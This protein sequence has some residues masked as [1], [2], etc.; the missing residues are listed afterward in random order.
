MLVG[1][2][3]FIVLFVIVAGLF[4]IKGGNYDP[5][6]PPAAGPVS[7]SGLTQPL[8]QWIFGF[9][10]Q[11]YGVLGIVS[12]ASV[13][14]FAYIGFDVVATTAEEARNPQKDLPR[15][16]LGSLAICTVLYMAVALVITGMV[17]YDKID[18]E[19]ALATAFQDSGRTGSRR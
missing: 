5:F 12:A 2:K 18:P 9:E 14:F 15:G 1:V 19:A 17:K 16:I 3:L 13:V 10:A 11:T 8:F 7:A 6:I 4:Y